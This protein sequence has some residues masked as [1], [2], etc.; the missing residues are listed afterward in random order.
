MTRPICNARKVFCPEPGIIGP[1]SL[2]YFYHRSRACPRDVWIVLGKGRLPSGIRGNWQKVQEPSERPAFCH[3]SVRMCHGGRA[4]TGGSVY[5][6]QV[7]PSEAVG[8]HVY[9]RHRGRP[10]NA[11]SADSEPGAEPLGPGCRCFA[12]E[13]A[14]HALRC[15]GG[16]GYVAERLS[17]HLRGSPHLARYVCG[18]P[19]TGML[20]FLTSKFRNAIAWT[21]KTCRGL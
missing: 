13:P 21:R 19:G 4:V 17:P 14:V 16:E 20:A 10:Q 8:G 1:C 11:A 5:S 2:E 6:V 9:F 3:P 12:P 7:H 15:S 18:T